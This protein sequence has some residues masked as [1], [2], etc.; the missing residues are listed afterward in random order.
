MYVVLVSE[1][2]SCARDSAIPSRGAVNYATAAVNKDNSLP[3]RRTKKPNQNKTLLNGKH[4]RK[5]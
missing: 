3:S 4:R 1:T 5:P 2:N